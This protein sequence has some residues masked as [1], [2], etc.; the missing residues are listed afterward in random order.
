MSNTVKNRIR[1]IS[2]AVFFLAMAIVCVVKKPSAYTETERR[3]LA[4]RPNITWSAILDGSF[5][6]K[7][8][9]A[10]LDQFPGRDFFRT[11]NAW[12]DFNIFHKKDTNNL[13][14][15]DGTIVKMEYPYNPNSIAHATKIFDKIYNKF[16]KDTDAKLYLTI[17]PDK[18]YFYGDKTGHLT[19]DYDKLVSDM[20]ES[21]PYMSYINV[22]DKLSADAYYATDLHYKQEKLLE[23]AKAIAEAMGSTVF[24]SFD[25]KTMDNPFYGVYYGQLGLKVQADKV[26]CLF[27][28]VLA[29]CKVWDWQNNKE[30]SIYTLDKLE[31]KDQYEVYL[32]GPLSLI[33]I[34]NPNATT[35]KELVVF[36]DSFGSSMVPLLVESYKKVTL[37]DVRYLMSDMVG[38]FVEFTNQDVLF[39]Y[40][41]SVLNSS[42]VLK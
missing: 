9:S 26:T 22:F 32:G 40:S 29:Q 10:A 27:N 7:F 41:T 8:E 36:R 30:I 21:L 1:A 4:Q 39:L 31:G 20:T 3:P 28:D 37:V 19:L 5:M 13:Y 2:L 25:A 38:R 16:I 34:E 35:D 17:I 12:A 15:V 6:N 18:N 23:A 14:V 11:I 42:E 24:D 33:T